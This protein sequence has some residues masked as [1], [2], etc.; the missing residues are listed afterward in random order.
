MNTSQLVFHS[1]GLVN[2]TGAVLLLAIALA[3]TQRVTLG[4]YAAG[5]ACAGFAF[6][7][8]AAE[9][10]TGPAGYAASNMLLVSGLLLLWVSV[11]RLFDRPP[12]NLAFAASGGG[13]LLL[14]ALFDI[15]ESARPARNLIVMGTAI[16]SMLGRAWVGWRWSNAVDRVPARAM[17]LLLVA[18]AALVTA[19]IVATVAGR[20][21]AEQTALV[22]VLGSTLSVLVLVAVLAIVNRRTNAELQR[23]ADHDDLTGALNRRA[24]MAAADAAL[25]DGGA[26]YVLMLDFDHFKQIN[27][28]HGHVAGDAVL[29]AAVPAMRAAAQGNLVVGRYGGE[30]FALLL[31][32]DTGNALEI[33]ERIRR[34]SGD[35]G[36]RALAGRGSVTASVGCAAVA[37]HGSLEHALEAA[38]RAL[39]AA[40]LAGRDRLVSADAAAGA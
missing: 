27:D 38:D 5:L 24:F 9:P 11:L 4:L 15:D 2:L 17:S 32:A 36:T 19:G 18:N 7:L 6:V 20:P 39:Y 14:L 10:W 13:L 8:A 28:R 3:G 29:A 34:A 26:A 35:G 16:A 31:R 22:A 21:T 30:E 40:K 25:N 33:A 1:A 12:R 37:I 23:L